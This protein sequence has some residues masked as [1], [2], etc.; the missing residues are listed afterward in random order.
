[1][2]SD[3]EK[4]LLDSIQVQ[5]ANSS[6]ELGSIDTTQD[7]SLADTSQPGTLRDDEL[8]DVI[9]EYKEAKKYQDRGLETAVISAL[10]TASFSVTDRALI[11]LGV[12][13]PE[14]LRKLR[15]A[16]PAAD[17]SGVLAGILGTAVLTGGTSA[18]AQ[19]GAKAAGS[20][21]AKVVAKQALKKT[22]RAIAAPTTASMQAGLKVEKALAKALGTAQSKSLAKEVVRKS[23][24]KGAGSAVEGAA[25]GTGQLLREDALGAAEFNA[26]N[27]MATAGTG[28]LYGGLIGASMPVIG[29]AFKVAGKGVDKGKSMFG[30][31]TKNAFDD[32][33]DAATLSGFSPSQAAKLPEEFKKA[34]PGMWKK[35]GLDYKDISKEA[36][37][38]KVSTFVESKNKQLES[39]IDE[40]DATVQLNPDR[41]SKVYLDSAK[42][43]YDN[44]V[45]PY[46]NLGPA[47]KPL[48]NQAKNVV[49]SLKQIAQKY[50]RP[51]S[52]T[53]NDIAPFAPL[54]KLQLRMDKLRKIAAGVDE[55]PPRVE[56]LMMR[57]Q[58]KKAYDKRI[59]QAKTAQKELE[60]LSKSKQKLLDKM[61]AQVDDINARRV[62][63]FEKQ[64]LG[65]RELTKLKRDFDDLNV[66]FYKMMEPPKAA[67]ASLAARGFLN[68]TILNIAEEAG[69]PQ[70]RATLSALNKDISYGITMLKGLE[71]QAKP[72]FM[73]NFRDLVYGTIG[74][75]VGNLPGLAIAATGR[76]L[77]SD[78]K[79][80]VHVLSGLEKSNKLV[81]SKTTKS[82]QNFLSGAKIPAS[83]V[84][85]G[86]MVK[87]KMAKDEKG[88]DPKTKKAAF[89][90]ISKNLG[91]LQSDPEHFQDRIARSVYA[92]SGAAPQ[93][94][95][96]LSQGLIRG[97]QFLSSKLPSRPPTG[98]IPGL[99][100]EYEPSDMDI[101]KFERY[102]QVVENP[103]SV[104]DDLQAGTLTRD[105]VEALAAV[106][107]DLYHRIRNQVV[108][109]LNEE[110]ME[111]A[112][113]RRIQLGILMDLDADPSITGRGIMRLQEKYMAQAGAQDEASPKATQIKPTM[114]GAR[115][116]K[117]DE[118]LGSETFNITERAK[119]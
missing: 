57:P 84:L 81:T 102:L 59:A 37:Q 38:L 3:E 108:E 79:R 68:N 17:L 43:I 50:Q 41:A 91:A 31:W 9:A 10:G 70:M 109:N 94:A 16:N 87:S 23:I 58:L 49:S 2:A 83:S 34:L 29:G 72:K 101:S 78:F 114:S 73:L 116:I 106:Y 33:V 107:P 5:D 77:D 22:A 99:Q 85:T 12:Y 52:L 95:D 35:V 92:V 40:L 7:S 39:F 47:F 11:K 8:N 25:F 80:I 119:S 69:G 110:G 100:R 19:T 75:G 51:A 66:A 93:T 13:T 15:E 76:F 46:E 1:M 104:L 90:N 28:A 65:A 27:L 20:V 24:A 89:K 67:E 60:S 63:E 111:M 4:K 82:I 45:A 48:Y 6:Q 53:I 117:K 113:S 97:V 42:N 32:T 71:S 105:H 88:K 21:G 115:E 54:Q 96:A 112:Y 98:T 30:Q 74:W 14:K 86:V 61:Q 26:E 64:T 44:F 36:R 118:R 103:L 55:V 62:A 18:V 56:D